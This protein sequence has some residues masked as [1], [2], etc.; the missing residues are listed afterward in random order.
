MRVGLV[1]GLIA[2]GV[3][4]GALTSGFGRSG[5]TSAPNGASASALSSRGHVPPRAFPAILTGK[6]AIVLLQPFGD[7]AT[8]FLVHGEHW[9]P[10]TKVTIEITGVGVSPIM[11]VV[12]MSG[13]FN[14]A[15]GQDHDFFTGLIPPGQYHVI[16]IGTPIT[17]SGTAR[18]AGSFQILPPPPPGS[19][20]PPPPNGLPPSFAP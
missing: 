19:L 18:A 7:P 11:P 8:V 15:I 12:D 2:I 6:P 5:P 9:R 1:V 4:T 20:P 3:V 17:G 14:Y 10:R 13:S 16:V